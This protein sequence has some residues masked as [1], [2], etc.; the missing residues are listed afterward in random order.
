MSDTFAVGL[1]G[2]GTGGGGGET[3]N[4]PG[5]TLTAVESAGNVTLN[6]DETGKLYAGTSPILAGSSHITASTFSGFTVRAAE[7]VSGT[8]QVLLVRDNGS[9]L[10]W[11]LNSD[12]H[13][14]DFTQSTTHEPGS[15][16]FYA[17]ELAFGIDVDGGG[18]G[19]APLTP[20]EQ[21]GSVNLN[22][23][24]KWIALR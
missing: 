5:P 12:W 24:S 16:G 22:Q 6:Q 9:L 20:L 1:G 23:S 15:A 10:I 11:T 8:N 2:G 19:E 18:P 3:E 21:A 7:V 4:P 13:Y 14:V 17:A